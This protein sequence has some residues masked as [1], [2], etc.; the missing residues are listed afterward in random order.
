[1]TV[2]TTQLLQRSLMHVCRPWP[3]WSTQIRT[4]PSS[5]QTAGDKSSLRAP[6]PPTN[7][8]IQNPEARAQKSRAGTAA[9]WASAAAP[10][11][12]IAESPEL[13][14]Y[15]AGPHCLIADKSCT[16]VAPPLGSPALP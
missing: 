14:R 10:A 13:P 4:A 3:H 9:V 2:G 16:R 7:S 11:T 8:P 6:Q 5:S 12:R 15:G 1:V